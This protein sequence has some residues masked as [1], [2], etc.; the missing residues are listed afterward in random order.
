MTTAILNRRYFS[1]LA[2]ASALIISA[3]GG[4]SEGSPDAADDNATSDATDTPDDTDDSSL[5]ETAALCALADPAE[6]AAAAGLDAVTTVETTGLGPA[7]AFTGPDENS[8]GLN[9]DFDRPLEISL[10]E[11]L[12][13]APTENELNIDGA[14]ASSFS[15]N[16]DGWFNYEIVANGQRLRVTA[17]TNVDGVQYNTPELRAI[18]EAAAIAW[19][20]S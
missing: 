13:F 15:E 3:C 10:I 4:S 17:G 20:T 5:S 16:D 8:E 7:C 9:A 14:T 11:G 6:V 12:E 1:A 2:I 19:V 18:G